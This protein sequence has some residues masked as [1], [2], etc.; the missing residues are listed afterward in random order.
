MTET[1]LTTDIARPVR[2]M[3]L[4]WLGY[5]AALLAIDTLFYTR[6]PFDWLYYVVNALNALLILALAYCPWCQK[7]AG[8]WFVPLVI[9]LLAVLPTLSQQLLSMRYPPLPEL[10][11]EGYALRLTPLLWMALILLAWQYPWSR[12]AWFSLGMALLNFGLHL[13]FHDP[14][15]RA[16]F[17]PPVIVT[18]I[19]TVSLLIV[20]YFI[21]ALMTR[22]RAQQRSLEA[23]NAQL[24]H[25]AA[26]LEEL[27]IS[28][29]RN[30]LARELHDTLAHTLSALSV[31][32]ETAK[33]YWDVDAT[34]SQHLLET[35]LAA[36]RAGLQET[37]RA[38]KS[39]RASPLDDLGLLLAL[40][41][42][43]EESAARANVALTLTLPAHAPLLTPAVEQTLYRIAQEALANVTHH[44]NAHAVAL[45]LGLEENTLAL[46]VQDDGAGF[47]VEDAPAPGH[48]GLA[49]MRERARMVGGQL[50]VTS[51]PGQGTSVYFDIGACT[52]QAA[53]L[54]YC[55]YDQ[56]TVC[57]HP[58]HC[59]VAQE[60]RLSA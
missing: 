49:G 42:L 26:A 40:R 24:L 60:R 19:Q 31:Q 43:A 22:L 51:A 20:G 28:R 55:E 56:Q 29:E 13:H 47:G 12:V 33:A 8:R 57:P 2:V 38:L 15:V 39:L 41:Q 23:A 30:R 25:Y 16:P 6:A 7:R 53:G 27:T 4:L 5:V 10:R 54:V 1:R 17:W 52:K 58:E 34:K 18:L 46:V 45:T 32:L 36:T 44:A 21:S 14:Q 11:A 59:P 48:F 35:A 37:R 3:A 9:V 50:R